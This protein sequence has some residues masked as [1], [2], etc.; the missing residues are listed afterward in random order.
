MTAL[1]HPITRDH[2]V[3][4]AG[5][6]RAGG[7]ALLVL[8]AFMAVTAITAPHSVADAETWH[9]NSAAMRTVAR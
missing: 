1:V 7:I 2:Q 6:R 8:V 9:G 3:S 5:L 4:D